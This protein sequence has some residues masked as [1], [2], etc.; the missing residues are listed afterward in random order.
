MKEIIQAI[1]GIF[2]SKNVDIK[3]ED[4]ENAL[5]DVKLPEPKADPKESHKSDP[6]ALP[7]LS[8]KSNAELI[9]YVAE[10]QRENQSMRADIKALTDT[11]GKELSE[12]EASAKAQKEKAEKEFKAKVENKVKTLFEEGKI[13]EAQKPQ[14]EKL[15]SSDFDTTEKLAADLKVV[16]KPQKLSDSGSG[17]GKLDETKVSGNPLLA[18]IQQY[19]QD[20]VIQDSEE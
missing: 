19:N 6:V 14:W 20:A 7:D 12:R 18:K 4:I 2:K 3:E 16:G 11:L 10:M 1:L 13:T 8:G 5:K 15:F 17:S 9:K